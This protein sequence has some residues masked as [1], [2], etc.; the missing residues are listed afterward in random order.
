MIGEQVAS[1]LIVEVTIL[2]VLFCCYT[3]HYYK[4]Y[5]SVMSGFLSTWVSLPSNRVGL[6]SRERVLENTPT[7]NFEQPLKFIAHGCIFKSPRYM[8][9]SFI[10]SSRG[11]IHT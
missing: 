10:H 1:E 6:L 9:V 2:A 3:V 8:C 5:K 7:P 11:I 4:H